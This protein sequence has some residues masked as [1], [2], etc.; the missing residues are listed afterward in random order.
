MSDDLVCGNGVHLFRTGA[1]TCRC[2]ELNWRHATTDSE[3]VVLGVDAGMAVGSS[4]PESL[5][6]ALAE[7]M[8]AMANAIEGSAPMSPERITAV[9]DVHRRFPFPESAWSHVPGL[10]PKDGVDAP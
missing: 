8:E 4:I 1:W 9:A 3:N 2:G 10:I 5:R 6:T 7:H